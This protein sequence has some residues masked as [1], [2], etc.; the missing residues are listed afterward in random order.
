MKGI[1]RIL[2]EARIFLKMPVGV[3]LSVMCLLIKLSKKE[4]KYFKVRSSNG[5][6]TKIAGI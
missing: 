6:S 1:I 2:L 4:S 5:I 3:H